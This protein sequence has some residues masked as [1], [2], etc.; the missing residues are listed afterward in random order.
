MSEATDDGQVVRLKVNGAELS[1]AV[2]GDEPLATTLRDRVGLRSVRTAC[3]IGICGSCTVQVEGR[4]VSSC[5]MLTAAVGE[6]SVR[7]CE[8]LVGAEGAPGRVQQAFVDNRAYQCSY[9]IPGMVVSVDAYLGEHPDADVDEVRHA[10]SG[11]LCRCGT[12]VSILAAV[13][14][15]VA[16]ARSGAAAA[17]PAD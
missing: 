15:L 4:A 7:T 8:G 2:P 1:V 5:L 3:G 17:T 16:S 12:Y 14:D 11:N 9:C 10:L 6:R 13:H